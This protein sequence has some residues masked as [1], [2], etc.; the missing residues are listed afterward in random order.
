MG[1]KR[2]GFSGE[3]VPLDE[4]TSLLSLLDSSVQ[5]PGTQL[6]LLCIRF[7]LRSSRHLLHCDT[8]RPF[9]LISYRGRSV[10]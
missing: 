9:F 5:T 8:G 2:R 7:V 10:C 6:H 3:D 4:P 1:L